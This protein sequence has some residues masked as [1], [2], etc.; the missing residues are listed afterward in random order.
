M[1]IIH[2]VE[3]LRDGRSFS[4]RLVKASQ[5]GKVIFVMLASFQLPSPSD[6]KH[7]LE[8]PPVPDPE[9][10]M[11]METLL[12]KALTDARVQELSTRAQQYLHKI[13]LFY[14]Q[15]FKKNPNPL[16][17]RPVPR[18]DDPLKEKIVSL[19]RGTTVDPLAKAL[20]RTEIPS[21]MYWIRSRVRL[22]D[23]LYIHHAVL[24][25]ASDHGPI[26]TAL[27]EMSSHRISM[28]ASL[29]HSMW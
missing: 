15:E 24:A 25:Y 28:V 14:S 1:N 29:D 26:S 9:G 3:I 12:I 13:Y 4:T 21:Q 17:I 10:L 2:T 23:D 27:A 8:M 5:R 18:T 16:E 11:D 22:E 19:L 20:P 7:S 6:M